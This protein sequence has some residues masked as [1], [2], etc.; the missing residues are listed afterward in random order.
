M[1]FINCKHGSNRWLFYVTAQRT[2]WHAVINREVNSHPNFVQY[3]WPDEVSLFV[4][5]NLHISAVQQKL[6][7]LIDARRNQVADTLLGLR[8]DEGSQ[9][10]VWLVTCEIMNTMALC[11]H[12]LTVSLHTSSIKEFVSKLPCS[13]LVWIG[14]QWYKELWG[15]SAKRL[16]QIHYKGW[17]QIRGG[18]DSRS[19]GAITRHNVDNDYTCRLQ[20]S[21]LA[22]SRARP[23]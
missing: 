16:Q 17:A 10:C 5:R 22:Y 1:F 21:I 13:R 15:R 19:G 3:S 11:P 8:R 14:P 20:Q 9:I 6:S 7:P 23:K 12:W 2:I 4:S 18:E